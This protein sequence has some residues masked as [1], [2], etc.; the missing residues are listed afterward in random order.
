MVA[1]LREGWRYFTRHHLAVGR[2][3]RLRRAQRLCYSGATFNT[4]G[5]LLAKAGF[6]RRGRL[7]AGPLRRVPAGLL[8]TVRG[9]AQGPAPAT[10][11]VG[12]GAAAPSSDVPLLALG[13]A[14]DP[15][16]RWSSSLR[17]SPAPGAELFGL[18]L[19]PRHAGARARRDA[20]PRLLLRLARLLRRHPDRAARRP[21]RLA[22]AFGIRETI[23]AAGILCAVVSRRHAGV[24]LGARPAARRSRTCGHLIAHFSA[25]ALITVRLRLVATPRGFSTAALVSFA[26]W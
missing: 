3:A 8:L 7:G 24:A 26:S 14:P 13:H 15:S 5:P 4:L 25:S 20:L 16:C 11:P 18:G 23:L 19:E 21:V 10:A 9:D 6:H 17:S 2:G 12:H 1:D 22:L